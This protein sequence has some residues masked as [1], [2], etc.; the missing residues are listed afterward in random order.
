M[1]GEIRLVLCCLCL[2]KVGTL[3][4]SL[5][6]SSSDGPIRCQTIPIRRL[7]GSEDIQFIPLCPSSSLLNS[8]NNQAMVDLND[9][10]ICRFRKVEVGG[11]ADG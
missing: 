9:V 4:V 8:V 1:D 3:V 2:A 6:S 7:R 10:S 11:R 5:S